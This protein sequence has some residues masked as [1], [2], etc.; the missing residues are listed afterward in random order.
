MQTK[1]KKCAEC[2]QD[3][4]IWKN[5]LGLKYCAQCWNKIKPQ[6]PLKQSP[7]KSSQ[8]PI[9]KESTKRQKEHKIYTISRIQYLKDH[10]ICFMN[11]PGLCTKIATT[12]QHLKGRGKYYLD[13]KYWKGSC[14]A[15]HSYAD[16]H[17]TEAIENGWALERLKI[18][19]NE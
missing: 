13:Q 12:I 14:M 10:P 17:P 2:L 6:V 1:L 15:C 19:E 3:K 11:I 16:T 4:V 18:E 5:H 7:I 9:P 8:K